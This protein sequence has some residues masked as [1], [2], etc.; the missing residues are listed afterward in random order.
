MPFCHHCTDVGRKRD[1]I[2][3]QQDN[4]SPHVKEDDAAIREAGQAMGWNIQMRCQPAK[5]PDFN[6]LDLGLFTAIQARQY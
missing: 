1:T 2:L 3:V 4:A 6:V 5:S